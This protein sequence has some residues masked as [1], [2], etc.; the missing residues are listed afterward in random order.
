[1]VTQR[2]LGLYLCQASADMALRNFV[3]IHSL[4]T[5]YSPLEY[6]QYPESHCIWSLR[7]IGPWETGEIMEN[8][9]P[10]TSSQAN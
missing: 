5:R 10:Q 4:N 9:A 1:M 8:G 2:R 7:Q 6:S 3:M